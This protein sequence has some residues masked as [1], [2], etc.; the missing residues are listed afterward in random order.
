MKY[1]GL[2]IKVEKSKDKNSIYATIVLSTGKKVIAKTNMKTKI[3]DVVQVSITPKGVSAEPITTYSK[4]KHFSARYGFLDVR[5]TTDG[6]PFSIMEME[7]GKEI[8]NIAYGHVG[9]SKEGII[10]GYGI[11]NFD[12]FDKIGKI[13]KSLNYT[14]IEGNVI[15]G[16]SLEKGN[17]LKFSVN[18]ILHSQYIKMSGDKLNSALEKSKDSLKFLIDVIGTHGLLYVF[19][20]SIYKIEGSG[21]KMLSNL[22]SLS[23]IEF[24]SDNIDNNLSSILQ[25]ISTKIDVSSVID[26]VIFLTKEDDKKNSDGTDGKTDTKKISITLFNNKYTISEIKVHTPKKVYHYVKSMYYDGSEYRI[27]A[28]DLIWSITNLKIKKGIY[29]NPDDNKF[30]INNKSLTMNAFKLISNITSSDT[31]ASD[32][33]NLKVGQK[34]IKIDVTGASNI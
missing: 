20:S 25:H 28:N 12:Y 3:E 26:F 13:S 16:S 1:Y 14:G 18:K 17:S 15:W 2:V 30:S 31:I 32:T 33:I 22:L 8:G 21:T 27:D 4:K 23:K 10:L 11:S 7:G 19:S 24:G 34:G 5:D 6:K 29:I 9:L